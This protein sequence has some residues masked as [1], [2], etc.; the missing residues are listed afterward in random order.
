M[1][2]PS[3]RKI[4]W[5][6]GLSS[7]LLLL[8]AAFTLIAEAAILLP[9]LASYQERW[10]LERERAAEV[11]TLAIEA[12]PDPLAR[13]SQAFARR[14]VAGAGVTNV[15]FR[16]EGMHLVVRDLHMATTPDSVDLSEHGA[17]WLIEPWRTLFGAPDRMIVARVKPRF[18]SEAFIEIDAAGAALKEDLGA[19][20][21]RRCSFRC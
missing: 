6:G 8:V 2:F 18:R 7:R 15:A 21:C 12:A 1:R 14:L 9:S 17:Q 13:D 4:Q 16:S 19:C 3:L 5:P 11:A 10:L 20:C